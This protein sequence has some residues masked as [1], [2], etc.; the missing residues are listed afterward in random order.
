MNLVQRELS[1]I[2]EHN[3]Q[4][5]ILHQKASY[6]YRQGRARRIVGASLRVAKRAICLGELRRPGRSAS[7]LEERKS[8]PFAFFARRHSIDTCSPILG[9]LVS[10]R[11]FP[12]ATER[13]ESF[14]CRGAIN[15]F[16]PFG[17]ITQ[18]PFLKTA[19]FRPQ[20]LQATNASSGPSTSKI[21]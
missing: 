10:P 17:R 12:Q 4:S 9:A 2:S 3:R 21:H 20:P 5:A 11:G 7:G 1:E 18:L 19:L 8:G 13:L 15:L 14:S 16:L 6:S